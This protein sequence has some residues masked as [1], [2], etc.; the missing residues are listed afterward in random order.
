MSRGIDV[1][2]SQFFIQRIEIESCGACFELS[3]GVAECDFEFSLAHLE[4][5]VEEVKP[6]DMIS[7]RFS[8]TDCME[9]SI[10]LRVRKR[11]ERER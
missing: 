8:S 4:V 2:S 10:S 11:G 9:E 3:L 5:I 7:V 6:F 1:Y